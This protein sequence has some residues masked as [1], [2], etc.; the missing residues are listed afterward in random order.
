MAFWEAVLT[1]QYAL[2][3]TQIAPSIL[4][5]VESAVEI[6]NG[7]N[8]AWAAA[9]A[10]QRFNLGDRLRTGRSSRAAV[11]FADPSVMRINELTTLQIQPPPQKDKRALLDLKGGSLYFFSREKPED[12][13]FRAPVMVGAIRGTEFHL[14]VQENRES[15]L[16]LLDGEVELGDEHGHITLRSGEE[17]QVRLGTAPSGLL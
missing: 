2:G 5:T 3:A 8:K 11:R 16:V 6:S 9:S 10:G 12:V 1:P 4:L 13:Q 7:P 14:A 17:S 15:R